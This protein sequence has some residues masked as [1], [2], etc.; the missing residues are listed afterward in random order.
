MTDHEAAVLLD[1]VCGYLGL[2]REMLKYRV[3]SGWILMPPP[4]VEPSQTGVNFLGVNRITPTKEPTPQM[5]LGETK[6]RLLTEDH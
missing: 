4:T 2:S 3:L 6:P 1:S 5:M